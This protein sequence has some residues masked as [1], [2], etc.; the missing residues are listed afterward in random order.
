LL[1]KVPDDFSTNLDTPVFQ[2]YSNAINQGFG[3]ILVRSADKVK[4]GARDLHTGIKAADEVISGGMKELSGADAVEHLAK[5]GTNGVQFKLLSKEEI[6]KKLVEGGDLGTHGAVVVDDAAY[7][8][9]GDFY[10]EIGRFAGGKN[11]SGVSGATALLDFKKISTDL[12]YSL[13]QQENVKS[14]FVFKKIV[15]QT[16][17]TMN[18][19]VREEL[20]R[21]GADKA[22]DN[23]NST[24][25]RLSDSFAPLLKAHDKAKTD[26]DYGHLLETFLARP[27]KRPGAR[28]AI[29]DLIETAEAHGLNK[30]AIQARRDKLDIQL[31]EVAKAFNPIKNGQIKASQGARA[32]DGF[33]QYAIYKQDL[34]MAAILTGNA[35]ARSPGVARYAIAPAF[36]LQQHMSQLSQKS[37]DNLLSNPQ[38]VQTL[39]GGAVA[40]PLKA[41][42]TQQQL[43]QMIQQAQA[44]GGGQQG[45]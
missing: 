30:L 39:I 32:Q 4:V 14:S 40:A 45:Q 42:Q 23:L 20:K 9:L 28:F 11:R 13:A 36:K 33:T 44:I 29:D 16:R 43:D 31:V 8:A 18:N 10:S 6:T 7:K 3:K 21:A 38:A 15:D 35:I 2:A 26:L 12:S 25:D 34:T 17:T 37:M 22:F 1:S 24:Y 19:S 27:G 5:H 41:V